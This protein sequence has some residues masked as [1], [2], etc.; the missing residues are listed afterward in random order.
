MPEEVDNNYFVTIYER[1]QGVGGK[2][3]SHQL[4]V[5]ILNELRIHIKANQKYG[6]FVFACILAKQRKLYNRVYQIHFFIV[7]PIFLFR[8]AESGN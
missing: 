2:A 1:R 6:N 4:F 3:H 5:I 7:S 8:A